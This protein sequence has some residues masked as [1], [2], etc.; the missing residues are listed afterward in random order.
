MLLVDADVAEN[1]VVVQEAVAHSLLNVHCCY[2]QAQR[3]QVE[4]G[5]ELHQ[6]AQQQ[7]QQRGQ[8]LHRL[9]VASM[10][11]VDRS[12]AMLILVVL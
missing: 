4:R 2:Q 6:H 10:L 1:Q 9:F 7:Q 12:I 8:Q 3:V 5:A 11:L